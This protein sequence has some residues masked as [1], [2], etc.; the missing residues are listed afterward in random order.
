VTKS[1]AGRPGR[2]PGTSRREVTRTAL[3]L[4]AERGFEETTVDDIAEALGVSRRTLFRYFASKNDMVWGDFD[5]VLAR[6]RR[7]LDAT[8]PGEPLHE[9]LGRAVVESNRYEDDQLPELR[10]RMRLITGVPALQA[11]STLRYAEWR[12]VIA[13]FVADR[14]GAEPD[15]L[16]PQVVAHAALGTSMAAFLVWVD[17]PASDLVE[18]LRE[19]YRLLG[20]GL[21]ELG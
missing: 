10:I 8:T 15:D 13:E 11:H 4:F 7:C 6:L 14:V 12:A 18:N 9:A 16:I 3:E 5:W 21:R 17:D 2:P 19:A 20:S 1:L